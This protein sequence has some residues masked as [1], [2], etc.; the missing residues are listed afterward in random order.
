MTSLDPLQQLVAYSSPD[1]MKQVFNNFKH[2]IIQLRWVTRIVPLI[3]RY[4][5]LIYRCDLDVTSNTTRRAR[6][7]SLRCVSTSVICSPLCSSRACS[8]SWISCLV[9]DVCLWHLRVQNTPF[10]IRGI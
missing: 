10:L 5:T 3:R 2:G 9:Y 6:G 7:K 8:M 1:M 4:L